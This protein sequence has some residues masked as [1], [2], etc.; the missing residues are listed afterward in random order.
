M[1]KVL[2]YQN[3]SLSENAWLISEGR[4]EY[5]RH[6]DSATEEFNKN[7]EN[8][9]KRCFVQGENPDELLT[10]VTK[11]IIDMSYVCEEFENEVKGKDFIKKAQVAFREKTNHF[12]SQS[13]FM[14][15]ARTWPQGYP[16]DYKTLE[17]VYRNIPMSSGIGFYLDQHFLSTALGAAVRGRLEKLVELLKTELGNRKEPKILDIAC[18]SCRELFELAFDIKESGAKANCIDFDSD[19]LNFSSNRMSYLGLH[20]GQTEFRKYNA[21]KMVSHERNLKEFGMRDVIYSTGLFD[22]LEDAVLIRM[23]KSL[24]QLLNDNGRLIVSFKDCRRYRTQEYHWF[25]DWNAFSQRKEEDMR[26]LFEKAGI[27]FS[28]LTAVRE[29]SGVII[30]FIATKQ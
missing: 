18:G 17:S 19:A 26:A 29:Q 16:G 23:I 15:R 1:E 24:Y 7:L 13:Y 9:E 10:A 5:I 21:L 22:Y 25:V 11:S 8:I 28:A 6:L 20:P 2:A 27:P 12:F 14:N 4:E 30:F 3:D